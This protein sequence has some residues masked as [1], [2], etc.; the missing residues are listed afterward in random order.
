M[1]RTAVACATPSKRCTW[2]QSS[3]AFV[4]ATSV[5]YRVAVSPD[6][7]AK[8]RRT[9]EFHIGCAYATLLLALVTRYV[10]IVPH[11]DGK[12]VVHAENSLH[13]KPPSAG[14]TVPGHPVPGVAPE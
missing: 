2:F 7:V 13:A 12:V 14:A 4:G 1:M 8:S 6:T 9:S 11:V 10:V 3:L 5:V